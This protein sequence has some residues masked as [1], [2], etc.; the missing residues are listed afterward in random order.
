MQ[1]I[2]L[3][4]AKYCLSDFITVAVG[5][6]CFN[7]LR[8]HTLPSA[9]AF[10]KLSNF[11]ES[12]QVMFGQFIV[13]PCMLL[14]YA[15]SGS[16]NR[17]NTL[18][19][20]RLDE[21]LNCFIVSFIG[22]LG[23]FFTALINDNIPER[24]TN[25]EL[26]LMLLGCLFIPTAVARMII[27]TRNARKI[28]QGEYVMK[29][30]AVCCAPENAEKLRRIRASE[31]WSGLK[32]IACADI[33]NVIEC[34][35]LEGL[36]VYHNKSVASLCRELSVQAIV[37]LPSSKGLGHNADI[38]NSLY[39]LNLPLFITPDLHS[40]MT[41][42]P[43]VSSVTSEPLIDIT[44]AHISPAAVN[45]KRLGDIVVS[46]LGLIVLSP[47]YLILAI[48]VKLDS[49]GPVFYRQRRI[50]Y[51]K[52]PFEII[53]FRTM[54]VDAE[55]NGPALAIDDDPR[56]TRIGRIMRKYRLDELPQFWNVIKGEMSLVGPRPER[57]FFIKQ[58][59]ERHPSYSLIH[60]VR[61]G[62]TSWGAVKYGY[63]SNV[64][65]MI[66]RLPYDMLYIENVS[67]GVDLK[68]LFHTIRTVI[69]G[70]G[71]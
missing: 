29:T 52:E 5:W 17:S 65:E 64:D 9:N 1:Q 33:D 26:M 55:A 61:P 28:R 37:L 20:S 71:Q 43:R 67:L 42:R 7:I 18:Y 51:H 69:K 41:S 47:V 14:L 6:L 2:V 53:K 36:P 11:L 3:K 48:A 35:T 45:L 57:D 56:A 16:Y 39:P 23:I 34:D 38:I 40:L 10:V 4:R 31:V 13:P 70:S 62:I 32:I 58:I 19:K 60:Q 12:Q 66:E 15:I 21:L 27:I 8:F 59:I 49:D 50:G 44:N 24:V 63:A 30:L 22:M 68:I 25:Y 54:R 46:T